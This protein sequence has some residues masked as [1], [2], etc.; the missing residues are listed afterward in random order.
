MA[1]LRTRYSRKFNMGTYYF[2][3][4]KLRENK[5]F[6]KLWKADMKLESSLSSFEKAG[7]LKLDFDDDNQFCDIM[8]S[9]KRDDSVDGRLGLDILER[10]WERLQKERGKGNVLQLLLRKV[11]V[12]EKIKRLKDWR[13]RM[14]IERAQGAI[15]IGAEEMENEGRNIEAAVDQQQWARDIFDAV[16]SDAKLEAEQ[17]C[18]P[19]IFETFKKVFE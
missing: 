19:I 11:S 10:C 8:L 2:A 17:S 15:E 18:E 12:P 13:K 7:P 9:S 4:R 6:L 16:D 14:N 1:S 3:W 5:N